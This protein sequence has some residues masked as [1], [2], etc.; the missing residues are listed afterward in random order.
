VRGMTEQPPPSTDTYLATPAKPAPT[1]RPSGWPLAISTLALVMAGAAAALSLWQFAATRDG[2]HLNQRPFVHVSGPQVAVVPQ[3]QDHDAPA[4][5]ITADLTNSGNSATKELKYFVRCVTAREPV[6]EPWTLLFQGKVEKLSQ[7]IGPHASVSTRCAF[8]P[9]QLQEIAAGK[10]H[11]YI[12]GD[13]VYRDRFD[14]KPLYRTQFSWL[15]ADVRLDPS[16]HQIA[17]TA[18]PQGQHNCADEECP[19]AIMTR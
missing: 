6:A 2:R 8:D 13:I 17:L 9:Q 3:P 12:L 5:A 16:G 18:V 14:D 15:L 7:V 10:L 1:A 19:L 4:L 11:G